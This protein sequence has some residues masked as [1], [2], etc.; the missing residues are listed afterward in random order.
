MICSLSNLNSQDL[1]QIKAVEA[2]VGQS[3]LAFSAMTFHRLPECRQT[4][5]NSSP[6][7]ETGYGAGCR[8]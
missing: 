5:K 2:E 7:K 1:D 3:L 6:G 8:Q 4:G